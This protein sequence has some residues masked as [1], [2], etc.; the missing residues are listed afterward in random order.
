[1]AERFFLEGGAGG[2][3]SRAVLRGDEA[4][5]LLRVRRAQAGDEI[6]VFDG[7]GAEWRCRVESTARDAASLVVVSRDPVDRE[8]GVQVTIALSP[9]KGPRLRDLVRQLSEVGVAR[10]VPVE[11]E[12]GSSIGRLRGSSEAE[13][14]RRIAIESAKQCGRNRLLAIA[15]AVPLAEALRSLEGAR[16]VADPSADARPL[17][18]ALATDA[19]RVSF[20]VGP[21]GGFT[22]EERA[23]AIAAGFVPVRLGPAILR[24]ETAALACA[25]ACLLTSRR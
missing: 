4:A 5:H 7:S 17:L 18:S 9:P 19:T 23:A 2:V 25:T 11:V 22:S 12:R 1:M 13:S 24:I 20:L 8:I 16:L 3:G 21:E 10:V 6:V 15:D 14:L